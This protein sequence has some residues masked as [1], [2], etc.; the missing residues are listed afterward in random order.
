MGTKELAALVLDRALSIARKIL[1]A[2]GVWATDA[3]AATT[4]AIQF[5][6]LSNRVRFVIRNQP[7]F[8]LIAETTARIAVVLR[9]LKN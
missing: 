5:R 8:A 2:T 4:V 6:Y 7:L 1:I 9:L 3:M